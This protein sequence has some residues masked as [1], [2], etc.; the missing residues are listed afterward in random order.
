MNFQTK[1]RLNP[2]ALASAL[3]QCALKIAPPAI[4]EWG[5]AMLAELH[6]V[7]GDWAALAWSIGAAGLLAKHAALSALLPGRANPAAASDGKFFAKETQMR[8][9]TLIGASVCLAASLLFFAA[10]SFR[11]AFQLSLIQWQSMAAAL[12][13]HYGYLAPEMD[14]SKLA[15][16]AREKHDAQGLAYAALR[17][18]SRE[19]AHWADEAVSID[20]SLTWV[21]EIFAMRN[22]YYAEVDAWLPQIERFAPDDA[23]PH[24]I[25]AQQV[26]DSQKVRTG[27]AY[28][29]DPAWLGSM[30]AAFSSAHIAT[31]GDEASKLDRDVELRYGIRDPYAAVDDYYLGNGVAPISGNPFQYGKYLLHSGDALQ[32]RGDFAGA[33]QDFLKAAH[34]GELIRAA[35]P[36]DMESSWRLKIMAANVLRDPYQRLIK[37]SRIQADAAGEKTYSGLASQAEQERMEAVQWTLVNLPDGES[38]ARSAELLGL[39]GI[40]L[41]FCLGLVVSCAAYVALK[42]HSFRPRDLRPGRIAATAGACGLIGLF[43]SSAALYWSY[44][45]YSQIVRAYLDGG[46]ASRLFYVAAFLNHL[47]YAEVPIRTGTLY[48]LWSVPIYFWAAVLFLCAAALV[49]VIARFARDEKTAAA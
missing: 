12:R 17:H 19:G 38:G 24:L 46:D 37:L 11:E 7:E 48:S 6:H 14:F 16:Q 1:P 43:V 26:R 30:D 23:V 49:V 44:R 33:K 2:R 21:Y 5:H 15:E 25:A 47:N 36:R 18:I 10:P 9:S 3:L 32:S 8:K 29:S 13:G 42:S 27:N 40:V 31:H 28:L 22:S 35:G 45:P 34:F 20:P 41:L 4:A 39:S